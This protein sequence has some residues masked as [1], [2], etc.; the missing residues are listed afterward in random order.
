MRPRKLLVMWL[1]AYEPTIGD[2]MISEGRLPN[3]ARLKSSSG[4]FLLD[5]GRQKYT[6][7]YGDHFSS[8]MA[9][10]I[11]GRWSVVEFNPRTYRVIQRSALFDPLLGRVSSSA[12]VFDAPYFDL[13]KAPQVRGVVNWG[14]HDPGI[15]AMSLPHDLRDEITTRFGPYP[16]SEYIYAFDW[17]SAAKTA[18]AGDA[19]AAALDQR[20]RIARWLFCD[21]FPD[22][23]LA[24]VVVSELHSMIEWMWHGVDP[25]HPLYA[26][27]S[28]AAA[29]WGVERVYEALDRFLGT[30]IESI[31]DAAVIAFSMHGMGPNNSDVP[32]MLL[33]PELLYRLQFGQSLYQ[34]RPAWRAAD[35]VP[36][37]DETDHWDWAIKCCF[38]A[39]QPTAAEKLG[40]LLHKMP[41]WIARKIAP[42]RNTAT[43]DDGRLDLS[44]DWMAATSY[45]PYWHRMRAFALPGFLNGRIRI[46]LSGRERVGVVSPRDYESVCD[47]LEEVLR[48]CRDPRTGAPVVESIE[49]CCADNP[50][51]LN[52][53]N[54]DLNVNWQGAPLALTHKTL[55]LIGPAPFRRTGG[56]SGGYGVCYIR[57]DRNAAGDG[58]VRSSFDVAPTILEMLGQPVPNNISG[59]SLLASN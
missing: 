38:K 5:H 41:K 32:T 51:A 58:G 33:L 13:R 2:R 19:L 35:G 10:E 30:L 52:P 54:A 48:A 49:R 7:L 50:Q 34:P 8:G 37:L 27:K 31:P 47:E 40:A 57:S 18:A 45:Q 23:D 44:L 20:T 29:R 4:R 55:G 22:W 24:L 9:P 12:V 28:A 26:H 11:S 42:A 1:D 53:S 21:R 3:L 15:A 46:N 59:R 16:A 14:A 36:L 6:G 39:P 56:H 25:S 43:E 17:P